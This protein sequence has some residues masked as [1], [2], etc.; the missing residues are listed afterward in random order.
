MTPSEEW[1]PIPGYEGAYEVSDLGRVRSLPRLVPA[2][3]HG[4]KRPIP[5][6]LLKPTIQ[7]FGYA[8]VKLAGKSRLVHWLVADAFLGGRPEGMQV[9][10]SNGDPGDNRAINLRVDTVASNMSD[11]VRHGRHWAASKTHCPQGHP[12]T[13]ENTYRSPG[14]TG[15]KCRTCRA[16]GAQ[17]RRRK[18]STQ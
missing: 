10:H 11:T 12:Y 18:M 16:A 4:G 8:Q 7:H 15:R 9:C 14:R 5:G 17:R 1:R 3:P 2:G 13:D 6:G